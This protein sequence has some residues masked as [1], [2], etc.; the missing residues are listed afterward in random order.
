MTD[1][2]WAQCGG[3]LT[4][5]LASGYNGRMSTAEVF[6]AALALPEED[7]ARLAQELAKSINGEG[8]VDKAWASEIERRVKEIR[9]GTVELVDG[10]EVHRQIRARLAAKR[11]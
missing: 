3:G 9:E 6:A 7:R 2:G 10:E 5:H 8:E 4:A 11:R 1:L